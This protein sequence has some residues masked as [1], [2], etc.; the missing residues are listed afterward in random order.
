MN[1]HARL[2]GRA[3]IDVADAESMDE[4][5]S[6]HF[7]HVAHIMRFEEGFLEKTR[8]HFPSSS[9]VDPHNSAGRDF[10]EAAV[11]EE[12]LRKDLTGC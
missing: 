7:K 5:Q 8:K 1:E 3:V 9:L 4:A 2:C 12:R 11:R 6:N 10:W